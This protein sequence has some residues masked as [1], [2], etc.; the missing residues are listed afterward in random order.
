MLDVLDLIVRAARVSSRAVVAEIARAAF[1]LDSRA[2]VAAFFDVAG[3][4][5]RC[6]AAFGTRGL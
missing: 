4:E 6:A 2:D 3:D 5:L 1:A